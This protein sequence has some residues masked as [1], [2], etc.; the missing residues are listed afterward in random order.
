MDK[1][2]FKSLFSAF[3]VPL[4]FITTADCTIEMANPAMLELWER[5]ASVVG[6]PYHRTLP[7]ARIAEL[8][9]YIEQVERT[10]LGC[11]HEA[12]GSVHATSATGFRELYYNFVFTPVKDGDGMLMGIAISGSDITGGPVRGNRGTEHCGWECSDMGSAMLGIFD[13]DLIS[14]EIYI[15]QRIR[16]LFGLVHTDPVGPM[17]F[18]EAVHPLDRPSVEEQLQAAKSLHGGPGD[19]LT[20]FRVIGIHDAKLRWVRMAGRVFFN[21]SNEP[22]GIMGTLHETTAEREQLQQKNNFI[23]MVS[24]ELKTPLTSLKGYLQLMRSRTGV[25]DDHFLST[26]FLRADRQIAK[27]T[28]TITSLL[29]VSRL[30]SGRLPL[31]CCRLDLSLLVGSVIGEYRELFPDHHLEYGC[32]CGLYVYADADKVAQVLVNILDNA[33]KFSPFGNVIT[34]RCEPAADQILV[35]IEDRGT[36]IGPADVPLIFD[37]FHR[38]A[39]IDHMRIS[40]FG[41]GLYLCAE[42]IRMH[43][44]RIWAESELGKG[45]ALSF[46]L[47]V[48]P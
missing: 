43:E 45:T 17:E 7:P 44:G 15:D 6:T 28:G 5:D 11:A 31:N 38:A 10:G 27:M 12:S 39:G 24:H 47:P 32:G 8:R 20:E 19:L 25:V 30:D 46:T 2:T 40:G 22:S 18:L 23:G 21:E 33:I 36:G 35:R 13:H 14:D 3:P 29:D 41:I 16:D 1:I 42:I 48:C 4:A 26:F 34:I 37:R 9:P